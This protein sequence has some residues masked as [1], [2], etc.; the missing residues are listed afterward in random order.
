M[1][2]GF[3]YRSGLLQSHLASIL[4]A[5][6]LLLKE[7][8]STAGR[9]KLVWFLNF[10]IEKVPIYLSAEISFSTLPGSRLLAHYSSSVDVLENQS[11]WQPHP[12]E[13][14]VEIE[15]WSYSAAHHWRSLSSCGWRCSLGTRCC[16]SSCCG[17]RHLKELTV[18]PIMVIGFER[19]NHIANQRRSESREEC[20]VTHHFG[21]LAEHSGHGARVVDA[22]A[23]AAGHHPWHNL[24][25]LWHLDFW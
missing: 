23:E 18:S 8:S 22:K 20:L 21:C 9:W 12:N 16:R 7:A 4:L 13:C 25:S 15:P 2:H 10:A 3:D 24:V 5:M 1:E 17:Q 6:L 14:C 11:A 19:A